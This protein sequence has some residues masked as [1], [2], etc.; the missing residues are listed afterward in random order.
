MKDRVLKYLCKN[1]PFEEYRNVDLSDLILSTDI[2]STDV[3][4][5]FTYFKRLGFISDLNSTFYSSSFVLHIEANDFLSRGGFF[6]QEELLKKNIEKLLLEIESLKP[7]VPEKVA[8][9][10]TIAAGITTA[11]GFIISK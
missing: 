7:S 8:T 4:A 11:L 5:I 3:K 6:V 1:Q 9:L 10:T 2:K